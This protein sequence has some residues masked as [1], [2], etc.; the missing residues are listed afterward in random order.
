MPRPLRRA[1][2]TFALVIG[3]LSCGQTAQPTKP[4]DKPEVGPNGLCPNDQDCWEEKVPAPD[5]GWHGLF[6]ASIDGFKPDDPGTACQDG[7]PPVRLV[8][9][10]Y[11]DR[12]I[13]CLEC[14][15]GPRQGGACVRTLQ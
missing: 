3:A 13:D 5:S 7:S 1:C 6:S 10:L 9:G 14:R 2:V 8:A 11:V 15:C 4:Y 12:P